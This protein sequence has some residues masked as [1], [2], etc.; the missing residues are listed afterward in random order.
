MANNNS[1]KTHTNSQKPIKKLVESTKMSY[2]NNLSNLT[3]AI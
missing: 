3:L 1:I 2:S